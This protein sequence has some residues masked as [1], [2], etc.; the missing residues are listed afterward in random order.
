MWVAA[1]TCNPPT[2]CVATGSTA[3]CVKPGGG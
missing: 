2:R 3:D 1:Q